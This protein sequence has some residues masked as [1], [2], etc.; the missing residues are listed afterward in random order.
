M[1]SGMSLMGQA[2]FSLGSAGVVLPLFS[3]HGRRFT[4][5]G[6]VHLHYRVIN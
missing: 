4:R 5:D 3:F 6:V 2:S 1:C